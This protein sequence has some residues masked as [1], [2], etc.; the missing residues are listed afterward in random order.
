MLKIFDIIYFIEGMPISYNEF[1][2][3]VSGRLTYITFTWRNFWSMPISFA[4][5]LF[6][7]ISIDFSYYAPGLPLSAITLFLEYIHAL[8]ISG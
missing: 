6:A 4:R 3:R 2:H 8:Y 7:D 5:C 1:H